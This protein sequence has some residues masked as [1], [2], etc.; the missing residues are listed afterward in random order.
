MPRYEQIFVYHGAITLTNCNLHNFCTDFNGF[1]KALKN[2]PI[3]GKSDNDVDG[4][5]L[6]KLDVKISGS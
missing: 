4:I 3:V 5:D 6:C 2:V 1:I